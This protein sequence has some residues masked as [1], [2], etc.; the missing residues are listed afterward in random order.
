MRKKSS[1][2]W[3]RAAECGIPAKKKGRRGRLH[4]PRSAARNLTHRIMHK[5][6]VHP[7]PEWSPR[8]S[9]HVP[10]V[11]T[12]NSYSHTGRLM[13]NRKMVLKQMVLQHLAGYWHTADARRVLGQKLLVDIR[14]NQ[15]LIVLSVTMKYGL[16]V[17]APKYSLPRQV[18]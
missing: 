1:S 6:V 13:K 8:T 16:I 5:K 18:G 9:R 10:G 2:G 12:S 11:A 15:K 4:R 3:N 17:T 7:R 14:N